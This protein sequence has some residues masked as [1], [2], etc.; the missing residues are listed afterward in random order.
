MAKPG[1][2]VIVAV[3]VGI[4]V[5]VDVKVG[6]AVDV[7]VLGRDVTVG[8]GLGPNVDVGIVV[9]VGVNVGGISGFSWAAITWLTFS[10]TGR[11]NR[12]ASFLW[13][14]LLSE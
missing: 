6:I 8:V 2:G 14:S 5:G 4:I 7:A 13:S 12:W 1:V 11:F 10:C 3:D 9:A